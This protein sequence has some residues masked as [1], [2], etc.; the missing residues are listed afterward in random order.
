MMKINILKINMILTGMFLLLSVVNLQAQD[1]EGD[2][3]IGKWKVL[4]EGT[5]SGDST[6]IVTFERNE[7]GEIIGTNGDEKNETPVVKFDRVDA[8]GDTITAYWVAMGYDVYIFLEK[9]EDNGVEGSLMDMF[10]AFGTR[11]TE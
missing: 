5:P 4:V 9:I 10:D 7:K 8:K 6:M 1:K 11:M 2:F 3:F